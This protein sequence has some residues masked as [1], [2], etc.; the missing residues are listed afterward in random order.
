MKELKEKLAQ[1]GL[2]TSGKKA[3]VLARLEH[4]HAAAIVAA[5]AMPRGTLIVCP[6]SVTA[7]WA[8]QLHEHVAPGALQV[9]MYVGVGR[10]GSPEAVARQDVIITTYGTLT[11]EYRDH[12]AGAEGGG[13]KRKRSDGGCSLFDVPW[14][15]VVLDEAHGIRN[16]ATK[17]HKAALKLTAEYRCGCAH[18]YSQNVATKRRSCPCY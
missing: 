6:A 12:V 2:P 9:H 8:A 18:A 10:G 17:G 3:D 5:D 15:R 11:S 16:R 13:G 4:H 1:A 14:R 7:N